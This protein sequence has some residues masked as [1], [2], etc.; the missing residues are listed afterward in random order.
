MSEA[1]AVSLPLMNN[2]RKNII[3]QSNRNEFLNPPNRAEFPVLPQ[4]Y[5]LTSAGGQFL[6]YDSR[7][8]GDGRI[9][10]FLSDQGLQLLLN[11]EHWFWDV[12]FKVCL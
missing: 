3:Q 7:F 12:T 2:V 5:Y 8:G 9:L 11:S 1:I 10:I 4:L 6:Q